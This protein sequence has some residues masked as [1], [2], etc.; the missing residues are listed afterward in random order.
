[1]KLPLKFCLLAIICVCIDVPVFSSMVDTALSFDK[2]YTVFNN[3][4]GVSE[5]FMS[6]DGGW[7]FRYAPKG[8]WYDIQVPGEAVMQGFAIEHDKPYVYK[9]EFS[10]PSDCYS[11]R[12]VLRFDGVYGKARLFV[13]G[14]FIREHRGGFTRWETDVTRQLRLGKKNTIEVEITDCIDDIS[15][16]SGY[17]HHPIGGIL[18]SVSLIIQ[19]EKAFT[20]FYVETD[21]DSLYANALLKIG[22]SLA[23]TTSGMS[24]KY[25]L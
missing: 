4:V 7:K 11:N 20:D 6:L 2:L 12:M 17:A 24:L 23:D 9:K 16:A 3:L 14:E 8:Q 13:N 21:L 22:Y 19:P 18:R 10:V 15:Y 1:M 5:T 25:T